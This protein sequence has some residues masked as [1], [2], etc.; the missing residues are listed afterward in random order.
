M[1]GGVHQV[2]V[3][4]LAVLR[5]VFQ[6]HGLGLDGDPALALELHIVEHLLGH[7]ALGQPA[8]FLD[9]AVG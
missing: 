9:Q 3:V 6:A 1:P 2:Q 5:R 8:A 4:G 7:L